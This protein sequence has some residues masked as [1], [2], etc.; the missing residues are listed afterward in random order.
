MERDEINTS[1]VDNSAIILKG[2]KKRRDS[3]PAIKD[4]KEEKVKIL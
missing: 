3:L 1:V 2:V 4:N